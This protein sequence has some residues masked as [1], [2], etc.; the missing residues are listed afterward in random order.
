MYDTCHQAVEYS[1]P[2]EVWAAVCV[3]IHM[4]SGYPPWIKRYENLK[5]LIV[6]VSIQGQ[7]TGCEIVM[8]I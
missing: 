3:L 7:I 1:F 5:A 6:V 8:S 2:A 4:L